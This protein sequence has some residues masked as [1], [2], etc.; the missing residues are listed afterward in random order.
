MGMAGD[1]LAISGMNSRSKEDTFNSSYMTNIEK[2][3]A[4]TGKN[5]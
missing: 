1:T 3:Y 2:G 4:I 5:S